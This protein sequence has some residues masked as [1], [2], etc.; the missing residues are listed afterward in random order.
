M[1]LRSF[2]PAQGPLLQGIVISVSPVQFW[3]PFVALREIDLNPV[4]VPLPPHDVV[5]GSHP[6]QWPQ[7][8]STGPKSTIEKNEVQF[9]VSL[10]KLDIIYFSINSFV[11][12]FSILTV[13]TIWPTNPPVPWNMSSSWIY[14]CRTPVAIG[15][16]CAVVIYYTIKFKW[17]YA[18]SVR[19]RASNRDTFIFLKQ[20]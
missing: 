10:W 13:E 11:S 15:V 20:S 9:A 17:K 12:I 7:I 14:F 18:C 8:Q 5:Q 4:V 19:A 3:P 16:M 6:L 1:R 2:I